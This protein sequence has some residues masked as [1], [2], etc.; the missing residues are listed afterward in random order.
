MFKEGEVINEF[1]GAM[2]ESAVREWLD[3]SL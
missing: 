2:P 3:N 1:L